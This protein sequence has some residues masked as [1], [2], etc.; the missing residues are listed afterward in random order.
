MYGADW[1]REVIGKSE[2][3]AG[4]HQGTKKWALFVSDAMRE[5]VEADISIHAPP[6]NG[7]NFP[8]GDITRRSI[9]NSIPRVFD[10]DDPSGWAIYTAQIKGIWIKTLL[11][12]L[13]S[14]GEPL[15]TLV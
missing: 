9:W 7:E 6:M 13:A 2:L 12:T 8:V 15:A 5:K 3:E 10:L 14:F 1:L 4:D 11:E